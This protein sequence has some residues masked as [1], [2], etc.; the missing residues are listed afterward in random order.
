MFDVKI[1]ILSNCQ[2][3]LENLNSKCAYKI[4]LIHSNACNDMV[5]LKII[6]NFQLFQTK[7]IKNKLYLDIYFMYVNTYVLFKIYYASI[8]SQN[9]YF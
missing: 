7:P 9:F 1:F 3:K 8:F 5:R 2:R 6:I 4:H